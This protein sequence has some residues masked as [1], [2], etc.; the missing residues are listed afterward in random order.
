MSGTRVFVGNLAWSVNAQDL[1]EHLGAIHAEINTGRDGRSKGSGI[2]TFDSEMSA[3]QAIQEMVDT[4]LN[5]RPIWLREYR[6]EAKRNDPVASSPAFDPPADAPPECNVHVGN[7]TWATTSDELAGLC[8]PFGTLRFWQVVMGR[9]GRS[10]GYGLVVF[11]NADDASRCIEELHGKMFHER[12][13]TVRISKPRAERF[14][15]RQ[16][17]GGRGGNGEPGFH[18]F[19]G[20]LP[21]SFSWQQL[22]DC[23]KEYGEVRFVE[24]GK[25][26]QGRSKGFGTIVYHDLQSALN[27]IQNMNGLEVGPENREMLVKEDYKNPLPRPDD[28]AENC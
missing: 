2:A 10:R 27:C 7:L 9:D 24:V 22:K 15:N 5:G 4:E 16:N 1:Q 13:L 21:W 17:V 6:E 11:D 14:D 26:R 25:D 23:A 19:V 3:Q 18:V 28:L 12:D 20:N 8:S